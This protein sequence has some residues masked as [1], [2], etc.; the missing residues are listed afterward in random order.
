MQA[1][2]YRPKRFPDSIAVK[3]SL[4]FSV[5]EN[6]DRRIADGSV[7]AGE[8]EAAGFAVH[9]EG[10]NVVATLITTIEELA[11]RVEVEAA[12]II[13]TGPFFPGKCQGAVGAYGKYPDAV[14]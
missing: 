4:L 9:T 13:P 8:A 7:M 6:D 10:G 12:R 14:V 1:I 3:H 2:L 5:E 11:G